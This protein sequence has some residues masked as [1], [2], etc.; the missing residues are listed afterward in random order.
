MRTPTAIATEAADHL[1]SVSRAFVPA[2]LV[3]LAELNAEFMQSVAATLRASGLE[4]TEEE[5]QT[6]AEAAKQTA[7]G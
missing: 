2:N 7:E 5:L 3:K 4:L 6:I 1:G